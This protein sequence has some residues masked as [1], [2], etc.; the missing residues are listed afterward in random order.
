MLIADC[1]VNS[2]SVCFTVI[3]PPISLLVLSIEDADADI[4]SRVD[5]LK[6]QFV[7]FDHKSE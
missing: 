5:A 3:L 1:F 6:V 4:C 7:M 2:P